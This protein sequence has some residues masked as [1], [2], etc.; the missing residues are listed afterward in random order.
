[1]KKQNTFVESLLANIGEGV[2]GVNNNGICTWMNQK[3]L[4]ML[5]LKKMKS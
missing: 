2:Y 4:N 5:G 1:M 3:A